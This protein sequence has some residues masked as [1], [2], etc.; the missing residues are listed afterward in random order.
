M[1]FILSHAAADPGRVVII[2]DICVAFMHARSDENLVVRVPQDIQGTTRFWRLKAAINGTRKASQ[3]WQDHSAEKV[4]EMGFVRN[5]INP[6]IFHHPNYDFQ[7]EQH[8]DDFLG[9]GM[10]EHAL[11][12][13]EKFEGA[14]L[15]KKIEILSNN[16]EDSN[17]GHFLKRI[18]TVDDSGW[19]LELDPRYSE[20]LIARAGVEQGKAMVTPGSKEQNREPGPELNRQGQREFRGGGGVAQYMAEHRLDVAYST[21][22]VLR[23]GHCP[24]ENSWKKLK[25]VARYVKGRQR[26]VLHFHWQDLPTIIVGMVDSDW[27]GDPKTR[28]ST[29]SGVARL[30]KH[31]LRH[32][33]ASQATISLSSGEAEAKGI[34]KGC[35]ELLYIQNLL[36]Q[37]GY[38]MGLEIQTDSSAAKGCMNRL[39]TG[40]RMKHLEVQTL[41]VQQLVKN[42]TIAITKISAFENLADIL[43]KYVSN[44]WLTKAMNCLGYEFINDECK[45]IDH[46]YGKIESS[47]QECTEEA[48]GLEELLNCLS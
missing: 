18:I 15:C 13:K 26:C 20:S 14:F 23:D 3:L 43:T 38:P 22:E 1:R 37:Q 31:L 30:G 36:A 5:D 47:E 27:A 39:G 2:I 48:D 9:S 29:S 42:N 19:H 35:V 8:G 32:W 11:V 41:W 10:R 17:K 12:L 46:G 6:C 7:L 33:C 34:T 16:A 45:N 21:K 44:D 4:M 28:C 24:G 40:K 25:R